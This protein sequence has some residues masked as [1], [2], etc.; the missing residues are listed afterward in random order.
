MLN[1]GMEY[2]NDSGIPVWVP[3]LFVFAVLAGQNHDIGMC[4]RVH[5]ILSTSHIICSIVDSK[6]FVPVYTIVD[7]RDGTSFLVCK[8]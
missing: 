4:A 8:P 3:F 7:K 1:I 6:H 5:G 2:T